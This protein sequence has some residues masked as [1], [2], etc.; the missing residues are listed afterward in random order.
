M[1]KKSDDK[2]IDKAKIN[3]DDTKVNRSAESPT[4]E[5]SGPTEVLDITTFAEYKKLQEELMLAKLATKESM[6]MV[7]NFKLDIDRIRERSEK[8]NAEAE[9]K[10]TIEVAKKLLPIIDDFEKSLVHL[11]AGS[12][13]KGIN[14]LYTALLGVLDSLSI[15]EIEAQTGVFNPEKMDAIM[16]EETSKPE[17]A[18][19]IAHV[20]RKG[21]YYVPTDKVIRYT[22]VSVYRA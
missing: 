3:A 4:C 8:A 2:K 12:D 16:A 14:M 18:G 15:K 13:F 22:Q 9:E 11:K 10:V 7:K 5:Q 20:F 19:T 6:E 1:A 17:L 21:Y